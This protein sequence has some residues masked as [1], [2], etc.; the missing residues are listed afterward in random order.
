MS[1]NDA[2]NYITKL[3]GFESTSEDF[4]KNISETE[5]MTKEE[6]DQMLEGMQHKNESPKLPITID[7]LSI[8]T[9]PLHVADLIYTKSIIK[10][11]NHVF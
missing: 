3:L 2:F 5:Q 8:D 10:I 6:A 4:D 7:I 1:L 9:R 11:E